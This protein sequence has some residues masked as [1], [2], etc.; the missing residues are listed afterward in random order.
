MENIMH[1]NSQTENVAFGKG[2]K[3]WNAKNQLASDFNTLVSD[4]EQLLQSTANYSGETISAAR[5]RFQ[6]TL[7][8]FK[9]RVSDAQAAAAG[10]WNRA[11]SA[12]DGYVHENPWKVIG[13]VAA[14]GLLVA[15]LLPRK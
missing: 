6:N 8:H 4:A 5:D 15:L 11:A 7:D 14:V 3:L 10:T 13:V 1:T 12:T 2:E 9:G